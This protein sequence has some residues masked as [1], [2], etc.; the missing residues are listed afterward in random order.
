MAIVVRKTVLSLS[1]IFFFCACS[2]TK[3]SNEPAALLGKMLKEPRTTSP[4]EIN[5]QLDEYTDRWLY[6]GG[7]GRTLLNVGTVVFFP[8]YAIYLLGNA[9]LA[10]AGY[11]PLYITSAIPE[12][13][14]KYVLG[15]YDGLTSVPG[16]VSASISG[17]EFIE[18]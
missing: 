12:G 4:E 7:M 9:G 16:R 13:P 1:L 17:R 10:V 11:E 5:Q 6:G 2:Q 3:Q 14:R 18:R 8:P 15:A